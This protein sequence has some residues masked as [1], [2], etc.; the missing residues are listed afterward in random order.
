MNTLLW[1]VPATALRKSFVTS[2]FCPEIGITS[3][4]Q[5][6]LDCGAI[7]W[8]DDAD[9]VVAVVV[10]S[11]LAVVVVKRKKTAITYDPPTPSV[12]SLVVI[13]GYLS[14]LSITTIISYIILH[15]K[16][17]FVLYQIIKVHKCLHVW[18]RLKIY[19]L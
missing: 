19:A 6:A 9:V 4:L 7:G 12:V 11:A 13:S 10:V 2:Y 8:D 16:I 18:M 15:H 17:F 14:V 5:S 3:I 1:E